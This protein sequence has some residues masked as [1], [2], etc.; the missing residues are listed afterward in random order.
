MTPESRSAHV[1]E[2]TEKLYE[3]LIVAELAHRAA[4]KQAEAVRLLTETGP[5]ER[6]H[7]VAAEEIGRVSYLLNGDES[8]VDFGFECALRRGFP[9]PDRDRR[10]AAAGERGGGGMSRCGYR[11]ARPSS[12]YARTA[13]RGCSCS[14]IRE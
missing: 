7:A 13:N 9:R 2:E 4:A 10:Q 11:L 14:R 1:L 3:L 12:P 8:D 5:F 6:L